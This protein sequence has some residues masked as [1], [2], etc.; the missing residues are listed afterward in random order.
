MMAA[1][2]NK[3]KNVQVVETLHVASTFWTRFIGLLGRK[4]LPKSEALLLRRANNIHT[5][6][7]RF[8]IDVV[9]VNKDFVVKK[10]SKNVAPGILY[11]GSWKSRHVIECAAGTV[12]EDK[13]SVGDQLHV[14]S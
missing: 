1:L 6:F 12:T 7:M 10:I 4:S 11:L 8:P 9:F 13:V 5:C 2:W 14:D 3:S